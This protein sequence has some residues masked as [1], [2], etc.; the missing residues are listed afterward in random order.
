MMDGIVS[1]LSIHLAAFLATGEVPA[2]GRMPLSGAY[3]CYRV[4]ACA[5][6]RHLTVGALE[7]QFWRALVTA[8][9]LPKLADEQYGP[10]QRQ[11]AMADA[12]QD[13][14]SRRDRDEWL[15]ELEGLEACVGPVNDLAEAAA[16][17]Q[18]KYRNMVARA[19]GRAVG[20]SSPF[21]FDGAHASAL[22]PAPGLGE[23]TVEILAAV[24]IGE[25]EVSELR[26]RG[27]VS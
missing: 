21:R 26:S 5:D 19:G 14:F 18:L 23:H 1:S 10:P 16:D 13:V 15:V 20:P 22:R 2:R 24:G 9:G 27:V 11:R 17:P 6:G 12:L 4:Y 25:E 8:V 7:P 3:A